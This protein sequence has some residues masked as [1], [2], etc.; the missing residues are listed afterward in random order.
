MQEARVKKS[1]P[2]ARDEIQHPGLLHQ[3]TSHIEGRNA[4]VMIYVDRIE[5]DRPKR[6]FSKKDMG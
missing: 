1:T 2:M 3:F 6:A 4:Q 5:W